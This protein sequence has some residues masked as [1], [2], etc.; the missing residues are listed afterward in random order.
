MFLVVVF[1]G[2]YLETLWADWAVQRI[3][4]KDF[5]NLTI[6]AALVTLEILAPKALKGIS[7]IVLLLM[8]FYIFL[9]SIK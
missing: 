8:T 6:F 9:V 1:L 5:H 4:N 2:Y 3:F 7:L